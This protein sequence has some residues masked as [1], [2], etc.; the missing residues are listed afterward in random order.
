MTRDIEHELIFCG[1][2]VVLITEA[3][4]RT[5]IVESLLICFLSIITLL[6]WRETMH[7]GGRV[8]LN[9]FGG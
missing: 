8:S 1:H 5:E 3:A 2:N 4:K 9:I 7:N 6:G